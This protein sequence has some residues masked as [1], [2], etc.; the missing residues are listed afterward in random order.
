VFAVVGSLP[1]S[2]VGQSKSMPNNH[3]S[4]LL[5]ILKALD[6]GIQRN[7]NSPSLCDSLIV[8]DNINRWHADNRGSLTLAFYP[9]TDAFIITQWRKLRC[10]C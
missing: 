10:V 2:S 1:C 7:W 5:E 6:A 8:K 3:Q 9:E 4:K